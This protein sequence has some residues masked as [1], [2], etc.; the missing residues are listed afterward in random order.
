M[1]MTLDRGK[2]IIICLKP[3]VNE[4]PNMVL[5]VLGESDRTITSSF[6]RGLTD[7]MKGN[8]LIPTFINNTGTKSVRNSYALIIHSV[9]DSL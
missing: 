4:N 2:E 3:R 1:N 9:P 8:H 6:E 5:I 7:N